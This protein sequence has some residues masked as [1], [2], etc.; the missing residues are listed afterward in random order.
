MKCPKSHLLL[1][2]CR[3]QTPELQRQAL[4]READMGPHGNS[5]RAT[6]QMNLA[7]YEW[8]T[9]YPLLRENQRPCL[10]LPIA[11]VDHA[12]PVV[13]PVDCSITMWE[14]FCLERV[15]M[16]ERV[17]LKTDRE[18]SRTILQKTEVDVYS[19]TST[20]KIEPELWFD[21]FRS[22]CIHVLRWSSQSQQ[23]RI[24][25]QGVVGFQFEVK[26][27]AESQPVKSSDKQDLC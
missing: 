17:D 19:T 10:K 16:L 23:V 18:K 25:Q 9:T 5:C 26:V 24:F 22:K 1:Q 6:A 13:K 12:I 15:K 11:M 2:S 8:M 14:S 3:L 7:P 20:M 27:L 4:T 21:W